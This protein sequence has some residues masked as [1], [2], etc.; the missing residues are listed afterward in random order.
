MKQYGIDHNYTPL[1]DEEIDLL[2]RSFKVERPSAGLRYIR[3]HFRLNGLRVQKER[4]RKSLRRVDSL[5][6]AERKRPK[7]KRTAYHVPRPNHL[8]H[9]D[10]HHK[11]ISWGFVIHGCI[12]GFDDYV[13]CCCSA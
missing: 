11:L 6:T 13:S 12:D 8:W 5:G 1:L 3:A 7:V 10:G 2:I 4:I 9:L